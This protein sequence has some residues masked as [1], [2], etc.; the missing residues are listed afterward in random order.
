M[1]P[2]QQF[3][4][5]I[6]LGVCRCSRSGAGCIRAESPFRAA[7]GLLRRF[8][9]RKKVSCDGVAP[10]FPPAKRG[11]GSRPSK[12]PLSSNAGRPK[13]GAELAMT[14]DF[15]IASEAK[16]SRGGPA[17]LATRVQFI[18]LW[19]P[20]GY[21]PS[22]PVACA[23]GSNPPAGPNSPP[24]LSYSAFRGWRAFQAAYCSFMQ[25]PQGL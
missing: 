24:A 25:V 4:A 5:W 11:G 1:T 9:P 3:D 2:C 18:S 20:T 12:R 21:T 6:V 13:A 16:Q 15:V 23:A 8:A 22:K 10:P 14:P 7:S 19:R 17:E